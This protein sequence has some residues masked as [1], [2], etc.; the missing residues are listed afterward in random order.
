MGFLDQYISEGRTKKTTPL[1]TDKK[2]AKWKIDNA[3]T[4]IEGVLLKEVHIDK[5]TYRV[6]SELDAGLI[7]P[8]NGSQ[9]RIRVQSE[10]NMISVVIA[11]LQN[12]IA[13]EVIIA[14]YSLNKEA[15]D[16]LCAL[17]DAGTIKKLHVMMASSISFRAPDHK[18]YMTRCALERKNFSL[19]YVYSHLKITLIKIGDI[20]YQVEGS[21]NYS[22]NNSAENLLIEENAEMYDF[23]R[24]FVINTMTNENQKAVEIIC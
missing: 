14:T 23:D 4:L 17:I 1:A 16:I 11:L 19:A 18:S 5:R 12:R 10:I 13:D 24:D 6:L 22:R 3:K 8:K 15:L 9:V 20:K 21:M 7:T 2:Y